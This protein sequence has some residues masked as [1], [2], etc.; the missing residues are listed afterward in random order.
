MAGFL[1]K[2]RRLIDYKITEN[3]RMQMSSGDIRFKYYT[4]SDRSINY[5]SKISK[6]RKVSDAEFYYLPFEVSTDPGSNINPEYY[7]TSELSFEINSDTF[8]NLKSVQKSISESL[9]SKKILS[10]KKITNSNVSTDQDN[11]GL[12]F[13][14]VYLRGEIDFISQ[15][16]TR[17]YPTLDF[18]EENIDNIENV[19]KDSRFSQHLKNKKL[20][21]LNSRGLSL[22]TI[23]ED[24]TESLKDFLFKSL[25]LSN[26]ID[27][28]DDRDKI[29]SKSI[30]VLRKSPEKVFS[31]EY[32]LDSSFTSS[33][34]TFTFELH[35]VTDGKLN[36][37]AFVD[38]GKIFDE[39]KNK[40]YSVYIIGKF[41]KKDNE[42]EFTNIENKTYRH[43]KIS[44]FKFINMFTLVVE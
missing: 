1:N 26:S 15:N 24:E 5:E 41:L 29:I 36:K 28:G 14:N 8:F 10:E 6:N 35:S 43:S 33:Q 38:L 2:K 32:V 20:T 21:P 23:I 22:T 17:Q 16:F 9:F 37:L 40:V 3:G 25:D 13:S 4:F 27:V 18:L 19:K 39:A 7:L 30:D 42:E 11:R 31:L 44:D 34:D 12:F